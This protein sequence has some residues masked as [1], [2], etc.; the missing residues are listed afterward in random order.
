ML[1]TGSIDLEEEWSHIAVMNSN[2]SF[3]PSSDIESGSD[4]SDGVEFED[5][6]SSEDFEMNDYCREELEIEQDLRV[7]FSPN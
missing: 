5:D 2:F 7:L 4:V 1:E 3:V 6:G